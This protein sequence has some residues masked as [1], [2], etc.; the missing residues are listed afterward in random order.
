MNAKLIALSVCMLIYSGGAI[1]RKSVPQTVRAEYVSESDIDVVGLKIKI[2][3]NPIV[4][5]NDTDKIYLLFARSSRLNLPL[6][7]SV[8]VLPPGSTFIFSKDTY[9][10]SWLTHNLVTTIGGVLPTLFMAVHEV[11]ARAATEVDPLDTKVERLKLDLHMHDAAFGLTLT[12]SIQ[13]MSVLQAKFALM[14][15]KR[16]EAEAAKTGGSP[17]SVV[18]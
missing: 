16:A 6:P 8:Y 11:D 13:P 17:V 7:V 5:M 2:R 12:E 3:G 9:N 10:R 4:F 18:E 1:A 14:K 15:R